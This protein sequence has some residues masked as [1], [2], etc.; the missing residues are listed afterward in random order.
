[1]SQ[2]L[3]NTKRKNTNRRKYKQKY[4]GGVEMKSLV[5]ILIFQTFKATPRAS[6]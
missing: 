6:R 5:N 4:R 1:M 3:G 2:K